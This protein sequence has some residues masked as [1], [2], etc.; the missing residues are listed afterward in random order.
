MGAIDSQGK[1]PLTVK[2][3]IPLNVF[4]QERRDRRGMGESQQA[5]SFLASYVPDL[6]GS[7]LYMDSVAWTIV[8]FAGA[9]IFSS[10]FVIQWLV[11][12]RLGRLEV[13]AAF[14]FLSF[15]G[16]IMNLLYAMHLDKAPLIAGTFFL[17][18]LYG[19]NLVLLSR[20]NVAERSVSG[21]AAAKSPSHAE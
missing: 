16:S 19:R 4:S 1:P 11:S 9:A 6:I 18:I 15:W 17:P 8:G 3:Q 7:W 5:G 12:E 20:T 13:P 21:Q 14:W 2:V 10:R